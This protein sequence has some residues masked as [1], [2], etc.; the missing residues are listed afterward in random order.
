MKKPHKRYI[1]NLRGINHIPLCST[2]C[3]DSLSTKKAV[4]KPK[5]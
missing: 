1:K 5:E 4:Q 2:Q 3:S